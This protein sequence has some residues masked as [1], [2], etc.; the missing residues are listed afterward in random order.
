MEKDNKAKENAQE[1]EKQ[2]ALNVKKTLENR[3]FQDVLG[4]N[5]VLSNPFMFGELGMQGANGSY[6]EATAGEAFNQERQSVYSGMKSQYQQM[7]IYGE[8]AMPSNADISA[9]LVQ[10]VKEVSAIATLGE[11]EKYSKEIGAKIDFEIPEKLKNASYMDIMIAMKEE[12]RDK[13]KD[14]YEAAVLGM[15]QTL[16]G[17]YERACSVNS[18]QSSYFTDLNQMGSQISE[19]YAP[20]KKED[21]E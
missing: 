5:Q 9:R 2:R 3:L 10:Q 19:M 4:S 7:G 18:I 11:L 20:K 1:R 6:S 14:D 16:T 21:G 8:P 17:F 15:H 12:G 13:P